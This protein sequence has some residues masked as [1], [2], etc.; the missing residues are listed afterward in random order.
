MASYDRDFR[1]KNGLIV[2]DNATIGGTLTI[3]GAAAAT[4]SYVTTQ[5]ANLID[6]APAS[7]DTLNELAAAIND[8]AN[9]Y[10]TLT[11][12]IA[13]KQDDVNL[14]L[15][16]GTPSIVDSVSSTTLSTS[17][18]TVSSS[19]YKW[20][21]ASIY[22]GGTGTPTITLPTASQWNP[23]DDTITV[24][25]WYRNSNTASSFEPV[26]QFNTAGGADWVQFMSTGEIRG[27]VTGFSN[28]AGANPAWDS[29]QNVWH[30]IVI[31]SEANGRTWWGVDGSGLGVVSLPSYWSGK[32]FTEIRMKGLTYNGVATAHYDDIRI[33][34]SNVYSINTNFGSSTYTVPTSQVSAIAG[35]TALIQ[36]GTSPGTLTTT[37]N[38]TANSFTGDG[39][40]LTNLPASGDPAGTGV[41]M[42]IALG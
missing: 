12:S 27:Y 33:T 26:I 20:G 34:T 10:T 24:E 29:T 39:S 1:V 31:V 7:L 21:S 22:S 9:V 14:T 23:D 40:N 19:Q 13:T 6:S 15:S 8:D 4:E 38:I 42:A 16:A 30:H 28:F 18:L 35:T 5:I 25:F 36:D 37:D 41:A 11:N 17:D 32:D 3:G 2:A